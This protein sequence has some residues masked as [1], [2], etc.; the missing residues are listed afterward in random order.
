MQLIV[1][2]Y[3]HCALK[4]GHTPGSLKPKS[5]IDPLAVPLPPS[6]PH[7]GAL[8]SKYQ[9]CDA[10]NSRHLSRQSAGLQHALRDSLAI[11]GSSDVI[12]T[13]AVSLFSGTQ[14]CDVGTGMSGTSLVTTGL[15]VLTVMDVAF[16]RSTQFVLGDTTARISLSGTQKAWL[17][18]TAREDGTIL[19]WNEGGMLL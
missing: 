2:Q 18:S 10:V 5:L 11:P 12:V 9:T 7:C 13:G 1:G 16:S 6:Y 4:T 17:A 14:T 3:V 8:I 19:Y 15:P